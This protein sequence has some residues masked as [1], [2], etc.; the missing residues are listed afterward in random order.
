MWIF[1][2]N[3]ESHDIVVHVVPLSDREVSFVNFRHTHPLVECQCFR[4]VAVYVQQHPAGR[5]VELLD[6]FD[7]F[8]E[9]S[10]TQVAALKFG[11]DIDLLQVKGVA[12]RLR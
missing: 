5:R 9:E 11:Q 3:I 7:R 6:M 2:S 4:I 10:E 12:V 8:A 1:G